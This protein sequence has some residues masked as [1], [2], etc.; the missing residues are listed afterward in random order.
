MMPPRETTGVGIGHLGPYPLPEQVRSAVESLLASR[1][2]SWADGADVLVASV[3]GGS[4]ALARTVAEQ[5]AA[6]IARGAS[7]ERVS[8]VTSVGEVRDYLVS[9]RVAK[10]AGAGPLAE[11]TLRSCCLADGVVVAADWL[12]PTG[13]VV[14]GEWHSS[15][16]LGH[17]AVLDALPV[18]LN[19]ARPA[20]RLRVL[21]HLYEAHRL[22]RPDL[23][24][25]CMRLAGT[26]NVELIAHESD[27]DVEAATATL[28]GQN[29]AALPQ[30]SFMARH[31]ARSA[32]ALDGAW[33]GAARRTT[34][35]GA[36]RITEALADARRFPRNSR[37]IRD[38][39]ARRV[40][41]G[42]R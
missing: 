41:G 28:A 6:V 14:V 29:P 33:E 13:L 23:C 42:L 10:P 31:E 20:S 25:A 30:I 18:L 27:I 4:T 39:V 24:L 2:M 35:S 21:E 5:C 37:R 8:V 34:L 26:G 38:A 1:D 22:L 40:R 36:A 15:R 17:S 16:L 3:G 12:L 32:S 11:L 19:P 7:P 9:R